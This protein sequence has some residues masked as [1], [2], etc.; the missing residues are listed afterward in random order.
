[1]DRARHKLL[2][3]K[4]FSWHSL[5][6]S[7]PRPVV[8]GDLLYPLHRL[9]L[10]IISMN[11]ITYKHLRL[12]WSCPLE[13]FIFNDF[14]WQKASWKICCITLL[15]QKEKY[16]LLRR[17]ICVLS[18]Q[19]YLHSARIW[20][21]AILAQRSLMTESNNLYRLNNFLEK[22]QYTMTFLFQEYWSSKL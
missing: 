10:L 14:P 12:L 21:G 3:N 6:K 2:L 9:F 16:V 19:W 20:L 8:K 17:K 1:M 7:N 18:S 22:I 13:H 11:V 5:E 4:G 15:N